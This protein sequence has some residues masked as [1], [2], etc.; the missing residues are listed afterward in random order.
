[1]NQLRS[2]P[3]VT[4]ALVRAG[5]HW[6]NLHGESG[7]PATQP[8][9][10]IAIS[11]EVGA[12]GTSVAR[13]IGQRLHWTVYDHEL[14]ERIAREMNL[15]VQLLESVDERRMSWLEECVEALTSGPLVTE[16]G[17]VRHLVQTLLSL[18]TH[19]EC[20]IVGRG[21]AMILPAETT[22][23]VR[24][25]AALDDRAAV[26]SQE[27]G[28]PRPAARQHVL[29][30]DRERI[31]FI[32]DHFQK[33][34]TEN[35][36]YDLVLNSSRFTV[37]ECADFIIEALQALERRAAKQASELTESSPTSAQR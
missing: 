16:S 33:D 37:G 10:T 30:S 13:E 11:R 28:V 2:V 8:A 17:Y 34:P 21:A 6:H 32:K 23:R 5:Q 18:A 3:Q 26:M 7:R 31:Q 4:E 14:V 24:L 25:V 36:H 9:F 15:R 12:R 27:L 35:E 19:G 29:A 1:M 22:L 20:I